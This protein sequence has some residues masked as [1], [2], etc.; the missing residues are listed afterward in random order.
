MR[1]SGGISSNC[2]DL[3]ELRTT[4]Q[5]AEEFLLSGLLPSSNRVPKN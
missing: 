4:A 2:P 1:M 5:S 3:A